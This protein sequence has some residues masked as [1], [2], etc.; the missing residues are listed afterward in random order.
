MEWKCERSRC[1]S[2]VVVRRKNKELPCHMEVFS[3][4]YRH[5]VWMSGMCRLSP[6]AV[7]FWRA[8]QLVIKE[9]QG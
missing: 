1:K 9:G 8:L 2:C 4:E 6:S 5:L 7:H 3:S